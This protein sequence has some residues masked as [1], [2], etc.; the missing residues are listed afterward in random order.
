MP[1]L[2][3]FTKLQTFSIK[4]MGEKISLTIDPSAY[5]QTWQDALA[6]IVARQKDDEEP[7]AELNDEYLVLMSQLI[8]GWDLFED[9]KP[10]PVT[11]ETFRRIPVG[12]R[13]AL[14]NEAQEHIVSMR[15]KDR[16]RKLSAAT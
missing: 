13:T 11:I 3:V 1:E 8:K 16:K 2:S 7:S 4:I 15:P 14:F 6:D 5:D 9:G 12:L 10:L